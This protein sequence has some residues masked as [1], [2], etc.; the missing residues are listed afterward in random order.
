MAQS[1]RHNSCGCSRRY[2]TQPRISGDI[3]VGGVP[4]DQK[5]ES[6]HLCR[7]IRRRFATNMKNNKSEKLSGN[8]QYH[9]GWA[10]PDVYVIACSLITAAGTYVALMKD[11]TPLPQPQIHRDS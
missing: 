9:G 11:V 7:R 1:R 8:K 3:E 2:G 10:N 6:I 5:R 4:T